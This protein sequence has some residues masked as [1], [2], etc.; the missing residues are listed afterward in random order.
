MST[1]S[2]VAIQLENGDILSVLNYY[3]GD[4]GKL[5]QHLKS[6]T[7]H[8]VILETI[9][10]GD[11]SWFGV[12]YD[13]NEPDFSYK[14]F[15][16]FTE[17][18]SDACDVFYFYLFIDGKWKCYDYNGYEVKIPIKVSDW[19]RED[20]CVF[21]VIEES[22]PN[23][24]KNRVAFIEKTPRVRIAEFTEENDGMNWKSGPKGVGGSGDAE[25][26]QIYGFYPYSRQWCNEQLKI[27]GYLVD[28]K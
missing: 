2:N 19:I 27:M 13:D 9:K 24:I 12:D 15:N 22:D 28:D 11:C 10:L 20:H 23:E 8:L 25:E 5:G 14:T 17:W 3:D 6:Y 1:A 26:K 16:S 4:P 7:D 18:I 21:R